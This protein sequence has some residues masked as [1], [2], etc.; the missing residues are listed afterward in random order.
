[1]SPRPPLLTA[2]G[3]TL[4]TLLLFALTHASAASAQTAA[5]EAAGRSATPATSSSSSSSSPAAAGQH[6]PVRLAPADVRALQRRVGVAVDGVLGRRTS[7][8]LARAERRRALPV[9]GRPDAVLLAALGVRPG[10][11]ATTAADPG[12]VAADAAVAMIGARY[13]SGAAGPDAFDCSGLTAFAFG[14]AG[15]ELPRSSFA[16]FRRG[17]RVAVSRIRR[18]DLVFFDTGGAGASDVGI[19]TS[20]TTVVS[21]TTRGVR[22]HAIFDA[23]WGSHLVGAR[24]LLP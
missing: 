6:A 24:R 4:A 3:L 9:D 5:P 16:Q 12:A 18:G 20:P 11:T 13:R 21:A 7:A 22:E 8:A 15:I 10:P 23:Y 17:T 19:A 1:V 14:R 2:L